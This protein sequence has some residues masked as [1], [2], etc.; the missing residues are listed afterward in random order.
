MVVGIETEYGRAMIDF[1]DVLY[2]EKGLSFGKPCGKIYFKK[3]VNPSTT[4][5]FPVEKYE[6]YCAYFAVTKLKL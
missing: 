2:V 3:E 1:E 5:E 6:E 4:I